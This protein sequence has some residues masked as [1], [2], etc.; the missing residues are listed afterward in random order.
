ML[1]LKPEGDLVVVEGNIGAGK[2]TCA[3]ALADRLNLR[4]LEEPVDDELL[5]LFYD[6]KDRWSFPFQMEMLHRRWAMQISAAAETCVA[7]GYDGAILDRSLWGD[8]VFASALVKAGKMHQKEWDIYVRAVRN[9][10][11]VLWP[12][13]VLVYLSAR[14]ETCLERI[15]QRGRPQENGM[16]LDYLKMI[17]GGYQALVQHA[18]TGFFPWSHAVQVLPVPWDPVIRDEKEMDRTADMVREMC[19]A[20]AGLEVFGLA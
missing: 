15:K 18:R 14:P 8:L 7:G 1:N 3:K 20:S 10:A 16:T 2:S 4:L 6:D 9:M 5:Q 17:H 13:T 19:T 12:P 11:L